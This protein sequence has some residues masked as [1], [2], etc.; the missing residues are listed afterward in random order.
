MTTI[1]SSPLGSPMFRRL[2]LASI[3]SNVGTFL[4]TVAASWAML[5]MTRSTLWV[6]LMAASSTLPLL[7]F[8]LPAGAMADLSDRRRILLVAQSAM[9]VAAGAT[10]VMAFVGALSPGRLLAAGLLLGAGAAFT[11]PSWQAMVPDLVPNEQVAGAVALNSAAFNVARAVGPALGGLLVATAGP[12]AGFGANAVSFLAVVAAL[13]AFPSS[14]LR[15]DAESIP[16]AIASGIRYA[17]FTPAY[18]WLLGIAVT[19]GFT[20]GGLQALLPNVVD[21]HLGGGSMTY[22]ILLGAMGVGAIAGAAS[23]GRVAA[24]AGRWMVPGGIG[25]FGVSAVAVGLSRSPVVT[26]VGM[27]VAGAAWVWTLATLNATAQLL[28]PAWVRGRIMSLYTLAFVGF[29]PLGAIATGA[30]G[31]AVGPG[32]AIALSAV[33]TIALAVVAAR[34]PLPVLSDVVSPT[35]PTGY[36]PPAHAAEVDTDRVVV[37]TTWAIDGDL[38]AYL[39]TMDELRLVRLRTGA[40]RWRL[41]HDVDAADRWTEIFV[42]S[43]WDAHLRQHRRIDAAGVEVLQ[44]AR[45][46]DRDGA[47]VTRHLAAQATGGAR[48]ADVARLRAAH[49]ALHA[50]EDAQTGP[51]PTARP[52]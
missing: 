52:A 43:S 3:V 9:A 14:T 2:W 21:V 24:A 49:D 7:F 34:V 4:H 19:F 42:C 5:Q 35:A 1:A 17:R 22:G 46:F 33:A 41:Y 15:G 16:S 37:E 32:P 39:A 8:A 51:I 40:V 26:A 44:R 20:T 11:L 30:L 48:A 12:A 23:R 31:T 47:P 18:R 25:L 29:L 38:E 10:A 50:D 6:G 28:S 27:L 45:A 13:I 36:D